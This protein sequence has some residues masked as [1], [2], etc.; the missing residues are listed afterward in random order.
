MTAYEQ[1]RNVPSQTVGLCEEDRSLFRR[2]L[3]ALEIIANNGNVIPDPGR[4]AEPDA[5]SSDP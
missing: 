1:Q 3:V 5:Q 4:N 2:L